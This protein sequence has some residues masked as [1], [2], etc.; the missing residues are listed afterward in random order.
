MALV[1]S[2]AAAAAVSPPSADA[3]RA[4]SAKCPMWSVFQA[5]SNDA[6][7]ACDGRR[8]QL[9]R[10]VGLAALDDDRLAGGIGQ[11]A[12]HVHRV[13]EQDRVLRRERRRRRRRRVAELRAAA[14]LGER[15]RGQ[16]AQGG[17]QQR[18]MAVTVVHVLVCGLR[19]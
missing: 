11:R 13:A 10:A 4:R 19:G 7:V 15:S 17:A 12:A 16:R 1:G 3:R 9:P 2:A 8:R 6:V 18:K 14:R 5:A